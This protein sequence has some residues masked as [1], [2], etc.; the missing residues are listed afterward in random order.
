MRQVFATLPDAPVL[1]AVEVRIP[2]AA[3][4]PEARERPTVSRIARVDRPERHR[5]GNLTYQFPDLDAALRWI[6]TYCGPWGCTIRE[7][8]HHLRLDIDS[9]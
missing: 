6:A 7:M 3:R 4:L 5:L 8:L 9:E 1:P 2:L